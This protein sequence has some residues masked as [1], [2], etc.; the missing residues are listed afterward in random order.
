MLYVNDTDIQ[1]GETICQGGNCSTI[2]MKTKITRKSTKNKK[3][4]VNP[5]TKKKNQPILTS[6][7]ISKFSKS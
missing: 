7:K 3:Q 6:P 5:R 2:L 4:K 1:F